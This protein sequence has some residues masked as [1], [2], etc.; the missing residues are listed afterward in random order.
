MSDQENINY[1]R[2]LDL[3]REFDALKIR[4]DAMEDFVKS[5]YPQHF[6]GDVGTA[7]ENQGPDPSLA[8]VN[9]TTGTESRAD[10][11][12]CKHPAYTKKYFPWAKDGMDYC[13]LCGAAKKPKG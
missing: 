10:P 8:P 12:T 1:L 7:F 3:K 5:Q 6:A 2:I 4:H 11:A 9:L 13:D